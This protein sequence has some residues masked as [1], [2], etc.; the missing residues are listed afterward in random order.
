MKSISYLTALALL[1]FCVTANAAITPGTWTSHTATTAVGDVGGITINATNSGST[2]FASIHPNRFGNG[3]DASYPLGNDALALTTTSVGAGDVQTFTFSSPLLDG[4]LMYIEN[5]DTSS[6]AQLT[7]TGAT[8]V[9]VV[10]TSM[11]SFGNGWLTS[12]NA[13]SD[14]NGDIILAFEGP[15]TDITLSYTRGGEG[16]GVF[17]TFAEPHAV[18][19]PTSAVVMAGLFSLGGLFYVR[20]RKRQA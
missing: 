7:A 13:T 1:G 19:E 2:E 10:S 17:Y 14:G 20:R 8:N 12:S 6:I 9:S 4:T 16:N 18:P 5:F 11:V 15:V 3:W